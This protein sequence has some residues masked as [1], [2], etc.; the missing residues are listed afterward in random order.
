MAPD[1]SVPRAP[2]AKVAVVHDWL[3]DYAG[4]ERVLREIL[5]GLPQADLF[6]LVDRP[7]EEL[8]DA[9]PRRAKRTT[10][11]QCL[12]NPK[13]WLRYCLP[14]M[15]AAIERLDVSGYDLVVSSSHAVAKGVRTGP[16]QL[17]VSYVHTPMRYAW[18]MQEEYLRAAGIERGV[19][20][21]AARRALRRLRRWDERSAQRVNVFIANSQ[22]VAG[23]IR[24]AYGREAQVIYP[25]VDV[26]CF[27]PAQAREDFYLTVSRLE[28]YKRVDLL[29]EAFR[30]L[31]GRRRVVIGAGPELARLRAGAPPNGSLLGRLSTEEVRSHLQRAR[32]FLFAGVEDFG[33][34]IAEAQAAGAPVIAYRAGGAAE[35]VTPATGLVFGAQSVTAVVEAIQRFEAVGARFSPTACRENA[36]RFD[37]RQF[38]QR[39]REVLNVQ[40]GRFSREL[41]D[42]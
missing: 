4:S 27:E 26:A 42:A 22:H 12:P 13:H 39:F 20:G 24:T 21:W 2:A 23:R 11:L 37:R 28:A 9:I 30:R 18:D 8:R 25:P 16:D 36:M 19:L 10:F 17:H 31:P 7:E 15:P 3:I 41:A 38:R 40:W 6:A 34:V 35:I 32:A 1:E 29:V 14:L 33:I 5:D